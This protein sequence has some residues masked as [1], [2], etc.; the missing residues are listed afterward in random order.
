[1][2]AGR[3]LGRP[4]RGRNRIGAV[5]DGPGARH[6]IQDVALELFI[7][8]G[9]EKTSL[10]EIAERLG[11][12][13]AALYYH[14]PT[15]EDILES[16]IEDRIAHLDALLAWTAGQPRSVETRVD[17]IHRYARELYAGR[18]HEVMRFFERNQTAVKSLRSGARMRERMMT[19]VE[20]LTEPGA[21]LVEQ[22]K[23]SLALFA[24]HASLFAIRD[25]AVTDEQR[26]AAAITVALELV[27][28]P[29]D[30]RDPKG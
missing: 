17:V 3:D 13:K 22:L 21:P 26:R 6:H 9:Y 16:L 10:R 20:A 29:P 5:T 2:N 14:F 1:M 23:T 15:K 25:P 4:A 24:M 7:E 27:G 19:L 11:V 28:A 12:T 18:H 30:A 8:H